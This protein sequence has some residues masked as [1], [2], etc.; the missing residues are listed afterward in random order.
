MEDKELFEKVENVFNLKDEKRINKVFESNNFK[1]ALNEVYSPGD[2]STGGGGD[3][4]G[5][6]GKGIG[7]I[8]RSIPGTRGHKMR[9]AQM[10]R[11]QADARLAQTR[12]AR[13]QADLMSSKENGKDKLEA[14]KYT[15]AEFKKNPAFKNAF[16]KVSKGQQLTDSEGRTYRAGMAAA[17]KARKAAGVDVQKGEEKATEDLSKGAKENR[18][19]RMG[20]LIPGITKALN[21]KKNAKTKE[22]FLNYLIQSD[23]KGRPTE[24]EIIQ[25]GSEL[26]DIVDKNKPELSKL[27]SIIFNEPNLPDQG[28]GLLKN[29]PTPPKAI[30]V[31]PAKKSKAPLSPKNVDEALK[32]MA[33]A[34]KRSVD[35]Q[36]TEMKRQSSSFKVGQ[37]VKGSGG[38]LYEVSDV[39]SENGLLT[40]KS[41]NDGRRKYS[42]AKGLTIE[43]DVM[44]GDSFDNIVSNL[45]P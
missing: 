35:E 9:T 18:M 25:L 7:A 32:Q 38:G 8:A 30:R 31:S 44:V 24:K 14:D 1:K 33:T 27:R 16:I 41:L 10:Q 6:I 5:S 22:S 21:D 45:L 28:K 36:K 29:L 43:Q 40:L 42:F 12:A 17:E 26:T 4:L 39:N 3:L 11:A 15:E 37:T 34:S 19:K 2:K 20:I 23:I 13:A